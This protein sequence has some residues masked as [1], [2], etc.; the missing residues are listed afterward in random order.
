MTNSLEEKVFLSTLGL[1]V[2]VDLV[3]VPK[4][5]GLMVERY[6]ATLGDDGRFMPNKQLQIIITDPHSR[7]RSI[8]IYPSGMQIEQPAIYERYL[9]DV[10]K[11]L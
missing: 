1:V 7:P 8:I 6:L 10:A 9:N 2:L 5:K 3:E 11:Y 4:F